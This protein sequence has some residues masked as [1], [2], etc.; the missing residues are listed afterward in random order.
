[1]KFWLHVT[2]YKNATNI[3]VAFPTEEAEAQI[4]ILSIL[5]SKFNFFSRFIEK[6]P[7]RLSSLAWFT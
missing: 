1:M 6:N 2:L 7:R 3:I 5:N 4:T